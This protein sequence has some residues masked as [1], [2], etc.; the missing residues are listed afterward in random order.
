M[1]KDVDYYS[2][3]VEN[4]I[5]TVGFDRVIEN[6]FGLVGETG[7][8]A[9]KIKKLIRDDKDAIYVPDVK[10]M[11]ELGDVLFY[12]TALAN[13]YGDGLTDLIARNMEKLDGR[14]E[15]GT[16]RGSGDNR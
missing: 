9:E 12:V 10:I 7:E 8:V 16:L 15:R 13:I 3:W 11:N 1:P 14:Q 6:T 4:K 5:L 2:D